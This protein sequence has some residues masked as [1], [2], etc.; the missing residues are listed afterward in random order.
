MM[1]SISIQLS[2]FSIGELSLEGCAF[3][4]HILSW[5]EL[6]GDEALSYKFIAF[7]KGLSD[8]NVATAFL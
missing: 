6:P 1:F 7:H 2:Y 8:Q 3:P 5:P 4:D